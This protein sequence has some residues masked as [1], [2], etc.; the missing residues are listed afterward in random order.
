MPPLYGHIH[1]PGHDSGFTSSPST[2][3]YCEALLSP[4]FFAPHVP[5]K[6][7]YSWGSELV[8]YKPYRS[9]S[10][11]LLFACEEDGNVRVVDYTPRYI[12]C[13]GKGF[14]TPPR[15]RA[16]SLPSALWPH[17]Q[18]FGFTEPV[19][20]RLEFLLWTGDCA[21]GAELDYL[22]TEIIEVCPSEGGF[23]VKYL[24]FGERRFKVED[25]DEISLASA[26]PS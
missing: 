3:V 17:M 14:A 2:V 19:S 21:T 6:S 18:W 9:G 12:P 25:H 1:T 8:S 7:F 10:L 23:R 4:V 16:E 15:Q 26:S 20:Q 13:Y 22:A 24:L 5:I 11:S